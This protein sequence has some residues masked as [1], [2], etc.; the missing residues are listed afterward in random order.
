M[1]PCEKTM[2]LN[3]YAKR[4]ATLGEE[5]QVTSTLHSYYLLHRERL[6]RTASH[7]D[8]WS[9][10][11]K[12][13]LEI[14]PFYSYTPFLMQEQGNRVTVVEGTDPATEPLK[15]LYEKRGIRVLFA[16]L[17]QTFA[18]PSVADHQL[19]FN[20]GDF[21]CICCW[22]TLSISISIPLALYV[23]STDSSNSAEWPFSLC[24]NAASLG[25]R[26]RHLFGMSIPPPFPRTK[27]ITITRVESS[28]VFIGANTVS[29]NS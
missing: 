25:S 18:S 28:W 29:V 1:K 9:V 15:P 24:R 3:E 14:G 6:W 20:A 12:S 8:V 21:D 23:I 7:F 27:A 19:P 17:E 16:D 5:A 13:V 2:T 22:K 26:L 10:R 11:Q 4:A